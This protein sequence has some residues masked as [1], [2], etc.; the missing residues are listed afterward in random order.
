MSRRLDVSAWQPSS[1]DFSLGD[2]VAFD[3]A[4]TRLVGEVVRVYNTRTL[5]HVSVRGIRYEVEVPGD[6]PRR[7]S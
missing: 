7:V 1:T 3:Y 2:I 4:G 5:F 6:N